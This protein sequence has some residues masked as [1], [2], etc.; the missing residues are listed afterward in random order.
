LK[1]KVVS[2]AIEDDEA[3]VTAQIKIKTLLKKFAKGINTIEIANITGD[4]RVATKLTID[5]EV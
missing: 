3:V 2:E 5:I 1:L 4:E